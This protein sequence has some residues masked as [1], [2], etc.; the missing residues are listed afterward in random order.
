M[1]GAHEGDAASHHQEQ[2]QA[3]ATPEEAAQARMDVPQL[4]AD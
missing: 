3:E 1:A 4:A 2:D